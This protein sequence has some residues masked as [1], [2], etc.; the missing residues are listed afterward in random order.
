MEDWVGVRCCDEGQRGV[1]SD[2]VVKLF[3]VDM[4]RLLNK[5]LLSYTR[6]SENLL[7]IISNNQ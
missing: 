7:T 2:D 1:L 6:P 5:R 4:E 3:I